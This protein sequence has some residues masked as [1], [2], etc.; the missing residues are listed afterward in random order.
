MFLLLPDSDNHLSP[1]CDTY[2]NSLT[3]V[4]GSGLAASEIYFFIAGVTDYSLQQTKFNQVKL[5]LH[6]L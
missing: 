4:S 6:F 1:A 3:E 5:K 2:F